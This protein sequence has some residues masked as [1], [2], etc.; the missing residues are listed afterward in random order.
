[1][2]GTALAHFEKNWGRTFPAGAR[3]CPVGCAAG[4]AAGTQAC[5]SGDAVR[6]ASDGLGA[7]TLQAATATAGWHWAQGVNASGGH[8]IRGDLAGSQQP[9]SPPPMAAAAPR[10]MHA[11]F[12]LAGGRLPLPLVPEKLLPDL[13]LLGVRTPS[14]RCETRTPAWQGQ[15]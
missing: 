2:C 9:P 13:W 5:C 4:P 8:S 14:R 6:T 15:R 3:P 7:L 1:M 11:A 10:G 12:A